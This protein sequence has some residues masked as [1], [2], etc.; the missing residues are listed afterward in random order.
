MP[1]SDELVDVM[2]VIPEDMKHWFL[3][4]AFLDVSSSDRAHLWVNR[5]VVCYMPC[6]DENC[7]CVQ[8]YKEKEPIV[9]RF[10]CEHGERIKLFCGLTQE[11]TQEVTEM[12]IEELR[13]L[14]K[15]GQTDQA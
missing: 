3:G 14:M 5:D 13:D 4:L 11:I 9:R 1:N 10:G 6:G 8:I 2:D 12:S 15:K 7:C